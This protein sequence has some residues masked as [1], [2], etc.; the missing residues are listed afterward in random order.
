MSDSTDS[1]IPIL[2]TLLKNNASA[3]DLTADGVM[4]IAF[5]VKQ[6]NESVVRLILGESKVKLDLNKVDKH[7]KSIIHY[8]INPLRFGSYENAALL[9][10]LVK[11]GKRMSLQAMV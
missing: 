1:V 5:V 6:N 3:N 8:V 11:A 9:E 10:L 4:P 2:R 7:G